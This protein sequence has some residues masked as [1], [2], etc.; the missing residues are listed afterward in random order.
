MH[1]Q[2]QYNNN[3]NNNNNKQLGVSGQVRAFNVH[4]QSKVL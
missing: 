2:G 4:I 3:N 1:F